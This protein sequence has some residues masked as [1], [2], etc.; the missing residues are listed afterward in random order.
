MKQ[1]IL[2]RSLVAVLGAVVV[3]V[4]TPSIALNFGDMMNPS[5]WMGGGRNQDYGYD[6]GPGYGYGA[7]GFGPGFGGPPGYGGYGIPGGYG[8]GYPGGYG[9]PG[10]GGYPGGYG[11]SEYADGGFPGDYGRT[12][13]EASGA[14]SPRSAPPATMTMP[15]YGTSPGD[16]ASE[17]AELQR[18][19][20]RVRMLEGGGVR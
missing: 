19:R 20:Q 4:A 18:L 10:Y 16:D 1:T 6:G 11:N 3:G 13:Q 8:S 17:Q 12:A 2:R 5:R 14:P 15:V 7:P 9:R